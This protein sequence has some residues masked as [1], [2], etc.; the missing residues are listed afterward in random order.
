V[1]LSVVSIHAVT[2]FTI[3][4]NWQTKPCVADTILL[5][6]LLFSVQ[7][8]ALTVPAAQHPVNKTQHPA[9]TVVPGLLLMFNNRHMVLYMFMVYDK[10]TE[11]LI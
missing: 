1:C 9:Q 2:G 5:F 8:V 3:L 6:I 7:T 10:N 4:A 11:S